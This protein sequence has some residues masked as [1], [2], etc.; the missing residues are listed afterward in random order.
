MGLHVFVDFFSL[1][2]KPWNGFKH[3]KNTATFGLERRR[4]KK[5]LFPS[6]PFLS[7]NQNNK[8]NRPKTSVT[9][10]R[11]NLKSRWKERN[12][13]KGKEC[14]PPP[15]PAT[16]GLKFGK[17]FN[18]APALQ[19]RHI[20]SNRKRKLVESTGMGRGNGR[21]TNTQPG[22]SS[23]LNDD[24]KRPRNHFATLDCNSI[25]FHFRAARFVYPSA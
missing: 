17:H 18:C 13:D 11:Q 6:S 20:V 2:Q 1:P 19:W 16:K 10:L 5:E 21:K 7:P 3:T 14:S 15:S 8:H 12:K 24:P 4:E 25:D 23:N 22:R 9:L